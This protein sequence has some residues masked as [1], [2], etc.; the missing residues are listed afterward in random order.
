[1]RASSPRVRSAQ[2]RAPSESKISSA[3]SSDSRAGRFLRSRRW[4]LPS[5]SRVRARSNGSPRRSHSASASSSARVGRVRVAEGRAQQPAAAGGH[6]RGGHGRSS[7]SAICSSSATQRPASS[8]LAERDLRLDRVAVEAVERRV[9]QP[10]RVRQLGDAVER[11][12]GGGC[13]AQRELQEAARGE[14]LEARRDGRRSVRRAHALV[15]PRARR[16]HATVDA[17]R[18]APRS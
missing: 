12:F 18:R 7:R 14:Q 15:D 4:T 11:A 10:E 13:I 5:T 17:R 3:A 16:I 8:R 2:S 6:D 1:M 9:A